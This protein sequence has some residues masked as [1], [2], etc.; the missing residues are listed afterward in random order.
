MGEYEGRRVV[1]TA[2]SRG[3]GRQVA[4][5]FAAE[6]GR[7]VIAAR[8]PQ[9]IA[10]V[11]AD[12][13]VSSDQEVFAF[14]G[15]LATARDNRRLS[16]FVR[17]RLGGL[18]VLVNA[19]GVFREIPYL[20]LD[21]ET[22]E[23]DIADNLSS[24]HFACRHLGELMRATGG[25]AIVNVGSINGWRADPHSVGYSAAKAAVLMLTKALAADLAP[26]GIRVN[27]VS[28]GMCLTDMTRG[29]L[30]DPVA[31]P[32]WEKKI[33]I[34]R[35]ASVDDVASCVLFLASDRAAYVTGANLVVD[36]GLG[37]PI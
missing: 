34:G 18:D 7:L 6:G 1:V 9:R 3:I 26:I 36:G 21:D 5:C 24:V 10:S 22:W 12:L 23:R 2:G 25:G 19:V 14:A 13:S 35:A 11:A 33:P 8:D 16:E 31:G 29:T 15:D 17:D 30:E 28:P 37:V 27:A 32:I 20:D 4:E